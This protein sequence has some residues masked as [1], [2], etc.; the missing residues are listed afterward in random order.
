MTFQ[1]GA[2]RQ[3]ESEIVDKETAGVYR[4]KKLW[5]RDGSTGKEER[6]PWLS[7]SQA[8]GRGEP[9]D[10]C[11]MKLAPSVVRTASG[12][13]DQTGFALEES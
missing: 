10:G 5:F 7:R 3:Y 6:H 4:N 2:R 8:A 11:L 13:H 9:R 12:A 1:S